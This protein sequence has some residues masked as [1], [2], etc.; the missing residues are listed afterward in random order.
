MTEFYINNVKAVLPD[1]F[2]FTLIEENP[3]I[4][5][6]GVY[7]FDIELSLKNK[8]N[9]KIFSHISRLNV[10]SPILNYSAKLVLDR[11]ILTGKIVVMDNTDISI[12]IQF[13]AGNSELNYLIGG[14]RKIWELDFGTEVKDE[15]SPETNYIE[16]S[17]ALNTIQNPSWENRFV[18]APVKIS[19]RIWNNW[20]LSDASLGIQVSFNEVATNTFII[21][22]YL[23]YY[24]DKLPSIL[25]YTLA[26]NDLLDDDRALQMYI[27]NNIFSFNYSDFLP[28]W[29]ISE[30]ISEI[31]KLFNVFFLVSKKTNEVFIKRVSSHIASANLVRLSKVM[32]SY[33]REVKNDF[34]ERFNSK[35]YSYDK[36]DVNGYFQYQKLNEDIVSQCELKNVISQSILVNTIAVSSLNKF[37][38]TET[39]PDKLDF[40]YSNAAGLNLYRLKPANNTGLLNHVNKFRSSGDDSEMNFRIV[41]AT[42]VYNEINV[43]FRY[44]NSSD[45]YKAPF[46]LPYKIDE[47]VNPVSTENLLQSIENNE[48]IEKKINRMSTLEVAL[49]NGNVTLFCETEHTETDNVEYPFPYVDNLPEYGPITDAKLT[50]FAAWVNANYKIICTETLRLVGNYGI[51]ADYYAND[52]V[53]LSHIYEFTFADRPEIDV[54]NK[55]EHENQIYIPIKFERQ[56]SNKKTLVKGCFY[57]LK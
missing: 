57:R 52:L 51:I 12:S 31:E 42:F 29:T 41:P 16:Y 23:M 5:N 33:V 37:Q 3:L 53:D 25:G 22:P 49:Y 9:A 34:P 26:V 46:Q 8:V 44:I 40:I 15:E 32:D 2:S 7:S 55:F 43:V 56:K 39:I 54:D 21:Q 47:V 24:I 27:P 36:S 1:D 30:F 17:R 6:I 45:I 28:D 20:E 4:T 13:V 50:N 10:E 48:A 14:D 35:R 18:C 19:D 38:I 11:R